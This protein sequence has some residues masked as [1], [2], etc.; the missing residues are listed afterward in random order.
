MATAT[1]T[2]SGMVVAL[3]PHEL[4]VC[5]ERASRRLLAASAHFVVESIA[6]V[7]R[8]TDEINARLTRGQRP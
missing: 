7:P 3:P 6:D 2:Q 8:T 5:L 1:F 4:A